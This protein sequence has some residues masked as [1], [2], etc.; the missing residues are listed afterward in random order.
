MADYVDISILEAAARCGIKVID[1][2]KAEVTVN[3]PF[4]GDNKKHL[5]LNTAKNVYYCH[6]CNASGNAVTLYAKL[7]GTDNKTAYCELV[8]G[9]KIRPTVIHQR[10]SDI[11]EHVALPLA[12]RH[13]VY[14]ELLKSLDLSDKHKNNLL[15]RGLDIDTIERNLYRTTPDSTAANRI[16]ENLSGRYS[17]T[18]VPGFYTK[19]KAWRTVR[20]KGFFIPVR[21]ADGLIQGLQIRLDDVQKRKCRWFSSRNKE[22]G[23]AAQ[24]WIHVAGNGDNTV[25]VSEGALKSDVAAFVTGNCVVGL[26]G[27]NCINGL[28]PLLNSMSVTSVYEA[29]DMD[30]R[31]NK[32][33]AAA[34]SNLR[35]KLAEAGITCIPCVWD[36]KF[37]GIDDFLLFCRNSDDT[38]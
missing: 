2:G 6:R 9:D 5:R 16:A 33:V 29:L 34:A 38:G 35:R 8:A 3:C 17:L 15:S 14:T 1:S 20:H 30:K 19:D 27:A 26:S 36:A 37:K 11:T 7:S 13:A 10:I 28:V 4:C 12:E 22:R 32:N 18:G 25:A 23:T 24:S 21:S 31:T